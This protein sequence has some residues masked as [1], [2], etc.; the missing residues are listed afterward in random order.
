MKKILLYFALISIVLSGCDK[1]NKDIEGNE[2]KDKD[3]VEVEDEVV[4]LSSIAVTEQPIKKEYYVGEVF[5]LQGMRVTAYY[6]DKTTRII[7]VI[8]DMLSYDFSTAGEKTVTI[9][10]EGKT[11]APSGII[12]I[13]PFVGSGTSALPFEISTPEQLVILSELTNA[14][15]DMYLRA[16]YKLTADINLSN[17]GLNWNYDRGWIPIIFKGNFEGNN[18]T[19]SGLYI[20]G[21]IF[22]AGLFG[23]VSEGTVQNLGV[24]GDITT[25]S[26]YIG[27]VVGRVINGN[28]TNC[29]F[30][31][32]LSGESV[33]GGV[34]GSVIGSSN[35]ISCYSKGTVSGSSS[36]V[37]G[38][39]GN[40]TNFSTL[41]GSIIS[42]CY[43]TCTVRGGNSVG[44]V[45]G[46]TNG[47]SEENFCS[48]SNCYATG[49][50]SGNNYVGGIAGQ[51]SVYSNITY[52]YATGT[53][54]GNNYVGGIAGDVRVHG[55]VTNCIALNSSLTRL[56]GS[57]WSFGFG[58]VAGYD[59]SNNLSG[60]FAWYN[61]VV[62]DGVRWNL[63]ED[64]NG[65]N[66]DYSSDFYFIN[67][68]FTPENGWMTEYG[69]LPGFGAAIDL[70][71]HLS[72]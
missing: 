55:S 43:S 1:D 15:I 24:E 4:T 45:V 20:N 39:V 65:W 64:K 42:K 48:I 33:V 52:C 62:T 61:M 9:T 34:V 6:S 35:I 2:D 19:I 70:P 60:N 32:S 59:D 41:G 22:G 44:G 72:W 30:V 5:I 16:H 63:D 21:N 11:T 23:E 7:T 13:A 49:A 29:Y 68:Y 8:A 58:R 50:V 54:S 46:E 28:I 69:K 3:K 38:V 27:G 25:S 53:V 67:E 17:Y 57:D 12:V 71:E 36:Q 26:G 56:P 31:G 14:N 51:V 10:Y 40:Q 66:F 47:R 18:H 37:G